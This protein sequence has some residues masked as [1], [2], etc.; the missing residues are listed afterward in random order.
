LSYFAFYVSL[1]LTDLRQRKFEDVE[2][3]RLIGEE[4]VKDETP[5]E[6]ADNQGM[7]GQRRKYSFPR[8]AVVLFTYRKNS[9]IS[10]LP[11]KHLLYT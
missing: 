2:V 5:G 3:G 1:R 11:M 7:D 10:I 8:Y 9:F 6:V 4:H